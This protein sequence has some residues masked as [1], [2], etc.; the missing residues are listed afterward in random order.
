MAFPRSSAP[1]GRS[2]RRHAWLPRVW[3]RFPQTQARATRCAAPPSDR[4]IAE[5]IMN[6]KMNF[7]PETFPEIS[8]GESSESENGFEIDEFEEERGGGRSRQGFS[9]RRLRPGRY[10]R[11]RPG[12]YPPSR[13]GW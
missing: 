5:G 6:D 10:G 3:T 9:A 13:P 1:D 7:Q 8:I 2:R 12:P 11:R 4:T